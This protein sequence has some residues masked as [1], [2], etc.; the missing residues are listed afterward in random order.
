MSTDKYTDVDRERFLTEE[1]PGRSARTE[2]A[3][4]RARVTHSQRLEDLVQ[5]P[6]CYS[7]AQTTSLE[8]V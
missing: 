8:H 7:P 5:R 1:G 2:F 6:K 3:R 4:D